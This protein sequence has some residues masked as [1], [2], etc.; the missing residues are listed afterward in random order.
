MSSRQPLTQTEATNDAF[1]DLDLLSTAALTRALSE[2]HAVAVAAVAAV[3]HEIAAA[4]DAAAARIGRHGR[5]VY[6]GAGT[7]GRLGLLDSV[8]LSPTFSWPSARSVALMA[9]G[10]SA[11]YVAVEGAED[12]EALALADVARV[13]IKNDDV[14]IALAASG[15]TPYAIAAVNAAKARG[16][17]TITFANNPNAPL[18]AAADFGIT[19][20]TGAEIISGSTRLKAG[21]SQK[22]ALNTFSTALMVRLGKVYGNLMVDV[23]ATNNKLV[24]RAM[25]LTMQIAKCGDMEARAALVACDYRVKTAVVMILCDLD[26]HGADAALAQCEGNLRTC[27]AEAAT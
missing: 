18:T 9:G 4:V 2:D 1:A 27:L 13:D 21:T 26:A 25:R 14:V 20:D 5:L 11:V 24:A 17:L 6:L 8:E 23:R 19:L 10:D 16:A 15:T 7:S 3:A 22:V 12:S